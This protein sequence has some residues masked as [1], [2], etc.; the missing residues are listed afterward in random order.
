M[1]CAGDLLVGGPVG[2]EARDLG[3]LGGQVVAGLDGP[4]A[5][6]FAGRFE[7]DSGAFGERLHA[8]IRE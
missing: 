6:V 7:L 5:R 1:L 4:F 3:F 2:R 8:E